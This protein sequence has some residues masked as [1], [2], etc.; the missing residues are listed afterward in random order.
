MDTEY[1][2]V[3]ATERYNI[4]TKIQTKQSESLIKATPMVDLTSV[5]TATL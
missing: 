2:E 4:Q 1:L 3:E 5:F